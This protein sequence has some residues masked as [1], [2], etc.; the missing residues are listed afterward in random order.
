[1]RRNLEGD[2]DAM[3]YS[4]DHRIRRSRSASLI[5]SLAIALSITLAPNVG[6]ARVDSV[7]GPGVVSVESPDTLAKG[8]GGGTVLATPTYPTSL[9]SFGL[10]ARRPVG[11]VSGGAAEGRINYDRHRNSTGRHVNVPVVL[12]QAFT[13]GTP[14]PN[15]TGGSAAIVGD[16][17]AIGATCPAGSRSVVV[18]VEDNSDSG[19]G[20][21]EFRIL[22]CTG[23]FALPPSGCSGPE[24]GTLRTGNIQVRPDAAAVGETIATA[25]AAGVFSTTP[26]FNGVELAGG[27]YGVGLRTGDGTTYGDLH[28]EFTGISII[29][30]YQIITVTGWITSATVVGGTV[31]FTGIATLDMGDGPPPVGGL[32]LAGTLTPTG[33]TVN[34]AGSSIPTLPKTDGSSA[35]E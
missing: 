22:Y 9:A 18:Q 35:V 15:G 20:T 26:S 19:A 6:Q 10:N 16:C 28:A 11:F 25:G 30:L 2:K 12:M 31:N 23:P 24:G 34:I 21:D 33:I 7:T 1:M 4:L 29:G 32:S 13:T 27:I 3:P 14:T 5:V 8:T 17:E